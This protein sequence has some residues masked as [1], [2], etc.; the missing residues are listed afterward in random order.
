MLG[1][2][3]IM[4]VSAARAWTPGLSDCSVQSPLSESV[5]VLLASP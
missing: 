3:T 2:L 4:A 1:I 5:A